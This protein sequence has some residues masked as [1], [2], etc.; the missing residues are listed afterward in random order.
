MDSPAAS[1]VFGHEMAVAGM[2]SSTTLTLTKVVFPVFVTPNVTAM[3]DPALVTAATSRVLASAPSMRLTTMIA[4]AAT[5]AWAGSVSV[6]ELCSA[7]LTIGTAVAMAVLTCC[8][9]GAGAG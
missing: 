8:T 1:T 6:I 4:G 2:T 9:P 7:P 3:V 5:T